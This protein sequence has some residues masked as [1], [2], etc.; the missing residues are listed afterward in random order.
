[1]ILNNSGD[2]LIGRNSN[3]SAGVHS[4][5]FDSTGLNAFNYGTHMH[6]AG[7]KAQ[8]FGYSY[9]ENS[10]A[11]LSLNGGSIQCFPIDS[12]NLNQ[13][14]TINS[15]TSTSGIAPLA[16]FG[17]TNFSRL[18]SFGYLAQSGSGTAS[19]F[20]NR[21]F[22]IYSEGGIIVTSGEIDVF[23]DVRTKEDI[24]ALKLNEAMRFLE[25]EPISFKYKNQMDTKLHYSYRA[26]DFIRKDIQHIVGLTD[27]N[28]SDLLE[29]E[30]ITCD[31]GRVF[32]LP[33]D[34]KLVINL[35]QCI[36]LLHLLI[37]DLY[38]KI[39]SL[40]YANN[41]SRRGETHGNTN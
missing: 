30:D 36:P 6:Y 14:V 32:H 19:G 41:K 13:R 24:S 9:S 7:G 12:S 39:E 23:S 40:E 17:T 34:A 22:T 10:Y 31:D 1:M 38:K 3:V 29:P 21:P 18:T 28:S 27:I 15:P 20:S 4:Y 8:L 5:G 33:G 37:K 25:L 11:T 26:Q 2:L 16:V 35:Q